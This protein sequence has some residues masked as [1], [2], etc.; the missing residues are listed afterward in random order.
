MIDFHC[1]DLILDN[2]TIFSQYI[3]KANSEATMVFW[4]KQIDRIDVLSD[5]VSMCD[6]EIGYDWGNINYNT[7]GELELMSNNPFTVKNAEVVVQVLRQQRQA[8]FM[9][10]TN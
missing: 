5:K 1:K 4:Y 3:V 9:L 8:K 2:N 7:E 6:R 10:E